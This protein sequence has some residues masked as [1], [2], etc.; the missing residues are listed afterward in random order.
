MAKAAGVSDVSHFIRAPAINAG[1]IG[2]DIQVL[3]SVGANPVAVRKGTLLATAFH[4]E[5]TGDSTWHAYFLRNVCECLKDSSAPILPSIG[6]NMMFGGPEALAA[7]ATGPVFGSVSVKYAMPRFLQGGVI[8]DVVNVEQALIA[9]AAGA[10]SVMS[11]E[12]IPADIKADGG[13]ARMSD[14]KMIREIC[15]AVKIPVMAK[16]RIGHFGEAAVLDSLDVDCIDE[17]EVLTP[18]DEVNHIRKSQFS[19]PFVC[20]AKNLG[21]ALRRIAEGAAMIRLKGNA[22]TGNV[23]HAVRHA[24]SVF[25]EINRLKTMRDDELFVY[26]KELRVPVGLVQQVKEAGR[27]PV[28]TFAAGGLATPADVGLLMELGVDGVFVGSGIFKGENPAQRARAMVQA[29]T[30]YNSPATVARVSTGLGKA[31]VG[32]LEHESGPEVAA[33]LALQGRVGVDPGVA[34]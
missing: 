23:L 5:V 28:V 8:M 24:R 7:A 15:N 16:A 3:A 29:C 22:G 31:M 26:A 11:L 14:P 30:H 4:P 20:G 9:E 2:K 34:A 1:K 27:L 6:P 25:G 10:C 19:V 13:I 18:A 17:S 21:E 12:R 32:L 33:K